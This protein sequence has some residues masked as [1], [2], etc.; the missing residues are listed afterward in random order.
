M[1]IHSSDAWCR[2]GGSFRLL[3]FGPGAH[4]AFK[5]HLAVMGFDGDPVRI[6]FRVAAEGFFDPA[7]DLGG[8]DARL[9][10]N[11]VAY[12]LQPL[13]AAGGACGL[14]PRV[15]PLHAAF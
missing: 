4:R 14:Q 11:G 13:Y 6:D 15:P 1:V 10:L 2:P 5:D 7:L 3:T 8:R 9:D 12:A